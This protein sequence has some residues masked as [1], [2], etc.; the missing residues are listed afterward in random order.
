MHPTTTRNLG[1]GSKHIA[2]P[3][4]QNITNDLSNNPSL[5]K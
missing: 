2:S 3:L 4:Q 1:F 5:T